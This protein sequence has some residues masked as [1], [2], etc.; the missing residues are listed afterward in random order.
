MSD[1][2]EPQANLTHI[3]IDCVASQ[4]NNDPVAPNQHGLC[5]RCGSSSVVPLDNTL[6]EL[7]SRVKSLDRPLEGRSDQTRAKHEAMKAK[8]KADAAPLIKW[9]RSLTHTQTLEDAITEWD[10]WAFHVDY[11]WDQEFTCFTITL[12]SASRNAKCWEI[13]LSA[14]LNEVRSFQFGTV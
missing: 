5:P 7:V 1:P 11:P 6:A 3:C 4:D 13:K 2:L 12:I 9:L 10:G 14:E 8:R